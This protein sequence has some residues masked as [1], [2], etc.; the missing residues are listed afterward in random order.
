MIPDYKIS[1][2]KGGF[3]PTAAKPAAVEMPKKRTA[4]QLPA[5]EI[6]RTTPQDAMHSVEAKVVEK[7]NK[8]QSPVKHIAKRKAPP[9]PK[10][11]KKDTPASSSQPEPNV[12]LSHGD[13]AAHATTNTRQVPPG[14]P[15]KR[16]APTVPTETKQLSKQTCD[17]VTKNQPPPSPLKRPLLNTTED[18]TDHPMPAPSTLVTKKRRPAPARPVPHAAPTPPNPHVQDKSSGMSYK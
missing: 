16:P 6:K 10:G 13:P 12:N 11:I 1:G 14:S 8:E 7:T 5:N 17:S 4:P 3:S 15:A 9:P 18:V 2:K